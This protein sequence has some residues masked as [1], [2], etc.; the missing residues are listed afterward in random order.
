MSLKLQ[1]SIVTFNSGPYLK[2]CLESLRTQTCR[3]FSVYLWD[4]ASTDDTQA[5]LNHY[6]D[7]L[8]CAHFSNNNAGFCAAHNR[9]ISS[10]D[11]E[12]VLVLNPDVVLE[13]RFLE[14]LI[15]R[16][17]KDPTAGSATGKLWRLQD[18]DRDS[19]IPL[20]PWDSAS[21]ILDSTG[22]YMTPNQRHFDRG[23]NEID[24]G[25]YDRLE[26]VFG[27]S[28]AAALYKR[29]MLRDVRDGDQVFDES[30]F[31]YREDV[32][33]AWRAQ[34]RGWRCLYV[35]DAR[36]YHAR[37]V[38]PERRP[39]LAQAINMHSFKNRFLL[40]VKNMDCGT[41]AHFFLPITLRDI[42][43]AIYVLAR[44]RSSLSGIPL[45][46]RALPHAWAQRKFLQQ[47]R[48]LSAREMRSWFSY[49]P[50][51]KTASVEA[52]TPR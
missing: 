27:A 4:N 20:I 15:R 7:I 51:A 3:D 40:R 47:H 8:S 9:L 6:Q 18:S 46:L 35:P 14:N 17:E 41:Y 23:S 26:Y 29:A 42:G 10:A 31:A 49:R 16:M 38:L 44:E 28:G 48:K 34:W 33:L 30:F 21:K 36:G 45:L 12:Y 22:I 11:S 52:D 25:Q 19:A 43:V 50:I 39:S 1:V 37:R 2:G 32:D 24:S 5:I 13:M